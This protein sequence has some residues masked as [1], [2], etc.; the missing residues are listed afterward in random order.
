MTETELFCMMPTDYKVYQDMVRTFTPIGVGCGSV[1]QQG[2]YPWPPSY[3]KP[4]GFFVQ[5]SA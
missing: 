1:D 4:F 2:L 3:S 5:K